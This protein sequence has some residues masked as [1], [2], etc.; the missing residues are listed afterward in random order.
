MSSE[1]ASQPT[2][3]VRPMDACPTCGSVIVWPCVASPCRDVTAPDPWHS[4]PTA[5]TVTTPTVWTRARSALR[6]AT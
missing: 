4:I 6:E 5:S 3:A 2:G 1:P